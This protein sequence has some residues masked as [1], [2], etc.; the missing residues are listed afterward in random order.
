MY[1]LHYHILY[2]LFSLTT[3]A[4][5]KSIG[6]FS[7]MTAS[8]N[9]L[10]HNPNKPRN[11]Y[12]C[13]QFLRRVSFVDTLMKTGTTYFLEKLFCFLI[14]SSKIQSFIYLSSKNIYIIYL[15]ILIHPMKI[16]G[17]HKDFRTKNLNI[18]HLCKIWNVSKNR[19]ISKSD[20]F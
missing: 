15:H 13:V 8:I 14:K 7:I 2:F 11:P 19:C 10:L 20:Q 3:Y 1:R 4:L 12:L 6:F 9:D 17:G 5:S 18:P 16:I